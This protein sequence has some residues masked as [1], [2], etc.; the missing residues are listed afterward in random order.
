MIEASPRRLLV[1]RTVV[2][3]GGFNAAAHRLGIAQPSAGAHVKALERQAGQ[4]LLKRHRGARPQLT[5]AGKLVYAMAGEIIRL[6]QE[7]GQRLADLKAKQIGEI[8]IAAHR[9]LAASFLTPFLSHFSRKHRRSRIV[10]RIGT[11]EDVLALV[12]SGI[13]QIGV[14]L[15]SGTIQGFSSEIIALEP[16]NL[17]AA[18]SH[19]LSQKEKITSYDLRKQPFVSGLKQSRYFQMTERALRMIDVSDPDIALEF[20][21][22]QSIKEALRHGHYIACL[23]ACTSEAELSAGTIVPLDLAKPLSP[24]EIRCIYQPNPSSMIQNL[25]E[26]LRG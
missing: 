14:L 25:I 17:L 1:F 13:A 10:T 16:L 2:D 23:P 12:E 9:D 8:V 11:I 4:A 6:S 18:K 19:P 24:L 26:I 15:T 20:Q 7:T 22:S 21:E 5:D 3:L